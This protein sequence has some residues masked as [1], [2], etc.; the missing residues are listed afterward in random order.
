MFWYII[1]LVTINCY[2]AG[3]C[4]Q[5][6]CEGPLSSNEIWN[7]RAEDKSRPNGANSGAKRGGG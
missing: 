3:S 7:F 4:H 6:T 5:V 2:K 1:L